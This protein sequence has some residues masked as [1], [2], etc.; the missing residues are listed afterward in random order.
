MNPSILKISVLFL[1][2]LLQAQPANPALEAARAAEAR[3]DTP[4]A[5]VLYREADQAE[6]N[7]PLIL[8]KIAQHLSDSTPAATDLAA[9]Q[10][11][12]TEALAYATRAATLDPASAVHQ[13]S[14]AICHGK[15]ASYSPDTRGKLTH[16][17]DVKK[18]AERALELDPA[19]DWAHHIVGRWH[20]EVAKLSG[21][22][23]F[24]IRLIYGGL[25]PASHDL[26]LQHFR[27]AIELAPEN[28]SH[29]LE[30]AHA[31]RAAGKIP[32]AIAQFRLGLALTAQ[33]PN[34]TLAQTRA[35][36]ALAELTPS[37]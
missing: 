20:Y 14:L 17:R 1:P 5:L 16:S 8:Q 12:A 25:P 19:Y 13:L 27:R 24:L 3:F 37:P 34:D 2:L 4:A 10:K 30:L 21:T 31:L 28:I 11:L 36:T 32:E 6:P 22:Q 18:Y 15:L 9:K 29:Q 23:R 33:N 7:N 26:A 35:T